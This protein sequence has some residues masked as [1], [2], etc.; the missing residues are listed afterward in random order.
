MN[1]RLELTALLRPLAERMHRGHC[2]VKTKDGPR[3][4][5]RKFTEIE[6]SEHVMGG[7]AYG[8]CPITPGDSVTQVAALDLDSHKGE[9]L[10]PEMLAIAERVAVALELD[11]Y[12]PHLFRSSGGAGIH[13]YLTWTVPQDAYSVREALRCAIVSC[14]FTSGTKGVAQREIE[15]FP[16]QSEVPADG[17]GS[18][19]ILPFAGQSEPLGPFDGWQDSPYVP[20]LDRPARPERS[21]SDSPNLAKLRSALDA[22]PNSGNQELNYDEWRNVCFGIHQATQDSSDGIAL[23]HAFSARSSKYDAD[24]LDNR[25]WP[26]IRNDRDAAITERTIYNIAS[27]YGWQDPTI[28]DEFEVINEP[29]PD[30]GAQLRF[31]FLQAAAF[32]AT[33]SPG[34]IIKGVLP[35]S[36]LI[37]IYGESGS[38]KSFFVLDVSGAIA[39]GVDWRGKRTTQA[40]V[41][42]IAA[43]GAAGFRRR[44]K[45]YAMA[46]EID[47]AD[48]DIFVLG[49]A[50]NFMEAKDIIDLG[51]ALRAAGPFGLVVVDTFAQV[52]PGA[53]ENAGE[54]VGRAIGHCKTL[55]RVTG[56]PV[57]LIHHS[58]KDASKG[59]RGW[60]GLRAAAD[61]EIEIV[62]ADQDRVATVTKLKDGEDGAEF[63]FKLTPIP[64]DMDEDDD[65]I[66]SC[67][68]E[69]CDAVVKQ[70]KK[71][72]PRG[73]WE[74]A[75][76]RLVQECATAEEP[77]PEEE[78][79]I[80][81]YQAEHPDDLEYPP[82]IQRQRIKRALGTLAERGSIVRKP[83]ARWGFSE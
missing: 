32:S 57:V 69:H 77:Y 74:I 22:I 81:A 71:E 67:V 72:Q 43:E 27:R 40:R 48:L 83:G 8:L 64:I 78:A 50:P 38:G 36:D 4:I 54:D 52:M 13:I 59:A 23:A 63:G 10:W 1:T 66:S 34:W 75:A 19:F 45:A 16:K 70:K 80:L 18:M 20:L 35:F 30:P 46:N 17:Y 60:S 53:N 41:A 9:T 29:T 31:Q 65:V 47:L 26:Y 79:I 15:I 42:Y 28:I 44:L 82:R 76:K 11:G 25:V 62:R 12:R 33:Q 14:G 56:A 2:W 7:N 21:I 5:D 68:V 55:R 49:D 58:G 51:N 37:V 3:R 6:L 61:A 39:R 73:N 24:F